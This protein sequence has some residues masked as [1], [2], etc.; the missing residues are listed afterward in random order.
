[1]ECKMQMISIVIEKSKKKKELKMN[2]IYIQSSQKL[3]I[4]S[5]KSLTQNFF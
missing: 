3:S 1:M 2:S 4:D 5:E